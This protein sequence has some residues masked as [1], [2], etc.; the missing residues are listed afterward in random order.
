MSDQE[1]RSHRDDQRELVDGRWVATQVSPEQHGRPATYN[2][3]GCR[4]DPCTRAHRAKMREWRENRLGERWKVNGRMTA[5]NAPTH[6]WNTYANWGCRCEA[7]TIGNSR[8]KRIER[9]ARQQFDE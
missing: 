2:N 5:V 7:C 3:Y 9:R 8:K 1:R 4:C 6:G